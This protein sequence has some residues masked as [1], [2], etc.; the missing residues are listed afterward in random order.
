MNTYPDDEVITFVLVLMGIGVAL[1]LYGMKTK[2][3]LKRFKS[4][5]NIITFEN[6]ISL[7]NIAGQTSQS[8]DFVT[9]DIEKMI[10]KKYFA[11]AHIDK[12]ANEIILGKRDIKVT[13]VQEGNNIF[14]EMIS[15]NCKGCGAANSVQ[16]GLS[17]EC[18]FCGS[19]L[20]S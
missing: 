9:K 17:S 11:N 10:K 1:I 4:Y 14:N 13:S 3:S 6:N 12:K 7:E 19:T 8:L 2:R 16:K 18:E 5:I 15:V 20:G